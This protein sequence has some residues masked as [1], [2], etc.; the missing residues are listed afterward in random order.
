MQYS[1]K[2]KTAMEE[3]K[4]IMKKYDIAGIVSLH[5]PGHGEHFTR[6][7]PSYSCAKFETVEGEMAIRVK[8][9]KEEHNGDIEEL[10]KKITDTANMF[11]VLCE[12][13][14]R[15]LLPL[16]DVSTKLNN[17]TKATHFKTGDDSSHTQQ[18]N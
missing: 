4:E 3:I 2:L 12:G 1:P 11:A 16:I 13:G 7:D 15:I 5:T 8:A 17:L 18:N 10:T 14:S 9:K 6:I